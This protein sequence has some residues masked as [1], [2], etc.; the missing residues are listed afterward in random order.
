M[1]QPGTSGLIFKEPQLWN[2]SREGRCAVSIFRTD[3]DRLTIDNLICHS[4]LNWMLSGI[5]HGF[6]NGILVW[7]RACIRWDPIP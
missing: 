1:S 7:T 4:F 6:L 5:I 2:K 3:V